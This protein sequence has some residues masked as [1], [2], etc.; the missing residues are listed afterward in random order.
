MFKVYVTQDECRACNTKDVDKIQKC[1]IKKKFKDRLLKG[2]C[3]DGWNANLSLH[4]EKCN[5]HS[6]VLYRHSKITFIFHLKFLHTM[7]RN[8]KLKKVSFKFFQI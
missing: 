8:N 7:P 4:P 3:V 2:F 1:I 5:I 6:L